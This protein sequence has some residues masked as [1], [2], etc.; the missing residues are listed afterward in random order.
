MLKFKTKKQKIM[1]KVKGGILKDECDLN[2]VDEN[3]VLVMALKKRLSV[4]YN[5][6]FEKI[7]DIYREGVR[8]VY[9]IDGEVKEIDFYTHQEEVRLAK[10]RTIMQKEGKHMEFYD[11]GAPLWLGEVKFEPSD[12][13]L[14]L[15]KKGSEMNTLSISLGRRLQVL[16]NLKEKVYKRSKK[17][18]K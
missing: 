8:F 15:V 1:D 11:V 13:Y 12:Y 18:E 6:N 14:K 16:L 10:E 3:V 9:R 17:V 4:L 7:D 2:K 5:A